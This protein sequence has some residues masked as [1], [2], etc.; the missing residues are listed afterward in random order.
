MHFG[1]KED[2]CVF[3]TLSASLGLSQLLFCPLELYSMALFLRNLSFSSGH[4]T[5]QL[6]SNCLYAKSTL[7]LLLFR[8][9]FLAT[10]LSSVLVENCGYWYESQARYQYPYELRVSVSGISITSGIGRKWLILVSV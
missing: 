1:C 6:L 5:Q 10:Y 9:V 8:S 3:A 2:Y 4:S 7:M